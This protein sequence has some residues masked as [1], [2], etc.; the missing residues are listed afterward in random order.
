MKL[1]VIIIFI[2]LISFVTCKKKNNSKN[3]TYTPTCSGTKSFQND[4]FPLIKDKC[5][6]C[7][8]NMA[9][10]NQVRSLST[11]IKDN[12]ISG[13]MPQNDKLTNDQKDIIVC[14]VEAGAPNN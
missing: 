4:V 5:W 3:D 1:R 6:R 7:H 2:A 13:A 12:V 9:D 11:Q 10:Y 8:S 14:W